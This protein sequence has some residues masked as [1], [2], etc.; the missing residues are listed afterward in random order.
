MKR[1]YSKVSRTISDFVRW[2]IAG[3]LSLIVV[4]PAIVTFTESV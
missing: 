4:I 3:V 2:V 1:V